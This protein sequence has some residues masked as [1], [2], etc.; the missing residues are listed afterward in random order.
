[1][2]LFIFGEG[3]T[4]LYMMEFV[5]KHM[6]EDNYHVKMER[7]KKER[8]LSI[9]LTDPHTN[10][11]S[12]IKETGGESNKDQR[13]IIGATLGPELQQGLR[14]IVLADRDQDD[15]IA[16]LQMK[17]E[18]MFQD[19]LQQENIQTHISFQPLD[20]WNNVL[21]YKTPSSLPDIRLIIHIAHINS[22]PTLETYP[23]Q[24]TSTDDYILAIALAMKVLESFAKDA[25]EGQ[26]SPIKPEILH[27]KVTQE[28]PTL[29]RDNG[30]EDLDAKDFNAIYMTVARFLKNTASEPNATFVKAVLGRATKHAKTDFEQAFASIIAAVRELESRIV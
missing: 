3:V 9:I 7:D 30:F 2:N 25:S 28:I 19:I 6:F 29:L 14:C 17:Y 4:D 11:R 5:L 1:M 15:T 18:N 13:K 16:S 22:I 27:K 12:I 21:V 20:A 8:K 26:V 10:T 23:F 24:N